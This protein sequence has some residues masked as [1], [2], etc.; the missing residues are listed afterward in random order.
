MHDRGRATC[1]SQQIAA[2]N[3]ATAKR[4]KVAKAQAVGVGPHG[5]IKMVPVQGLEPR[6]TRI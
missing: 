6:T 4:P 5:K 3:I 2:A 1:L